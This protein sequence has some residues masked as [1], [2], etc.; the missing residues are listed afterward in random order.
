MNKAVLLCLLSTI[1]V[2]LQ[3]K[4]VDVESCAVNGFSCE[5]IKSTHSI[6][7]SYTAISQDPCTVR[8][9]TADFSGIE[10]DSYYADG[11][12]GALRTA[13]LNRLIPDTNYYIQVCC[14]KACNNVF[15]VKTRAVN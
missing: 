14:N 12:G 1:I 9:S 13:Y 3:A 15:S 8:Y 6:F 4:P 5:I 10:M 7:L 2:V 11:G